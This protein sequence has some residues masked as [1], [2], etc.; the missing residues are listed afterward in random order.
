V[1][2]RTNGK[3]IVS[4]QRHRATWVL[5]VERAVADLTND[6]LDDYYYARR[7]MGEWRE[8]AAAMECVPLKERRSVI[9]ANAIVEAARERRADDF[10]RE[11]RPT[12]P[13][14]P[15][16]PE[17]WPITPRKGS[18]HG[19]R[20]VGERKFPWDWEERVDWGTASDTDF[21]TLNEEGSIHW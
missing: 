11:D 17:I 16:Q 21:G 14:H 6:E 10:R 15:D 8:W 5:L 9:L 19:C 3:R 7:V 2:V 20:W 18:S 4:A 1:G 12:P 13:H